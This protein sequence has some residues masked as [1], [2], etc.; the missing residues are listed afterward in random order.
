MNWHDWHDWVMAG[1]I[2]FWGGSQLAIWA[3]VILA[4]LNP[5]HKVPPDNDQFPKAN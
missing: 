2:V 5:C 3:T 4:H 1:A